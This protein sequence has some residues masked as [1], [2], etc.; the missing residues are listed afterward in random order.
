MSPIGYNPPFLNTPVPN[1][2]QFY[3]LNDP[4]IGAAYPSVR[5]CRVW[6]GIFVRLMYRAG[7]LPPE[8][9]DTTAFQAYYYQGRHVQ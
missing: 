6:L 8:C 5:L 1:E 3:S 7:N 9:R 2:H 4:A